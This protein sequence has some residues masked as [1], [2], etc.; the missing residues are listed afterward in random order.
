[1]LCQREMAEG[2]WLARESV[3]STCRVETA[4]Y[5]SSEPVWAPLMGV[6]MRVG[7]SG[8]GLKNCDPGG[9]MD[10][11]LGR[12]LTLVTQAHLQ[13]RGGVLSWEGVGPP[14]CG[15]KAMMQDE[16]RAGVSER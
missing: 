11:A 7:S 9:W 6:L 5:L 4:L 14:P 8:G 16:A 1:M 3:S 10:E 13:V 12:E 15:P 2:T